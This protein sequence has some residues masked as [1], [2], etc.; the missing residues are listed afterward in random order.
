[1][2]TTGQQIL[3]QDKRVYTLLQGWALKISEPMMAGS[4][5]SSSHMMLCSRKR[6]PTC[7]SWTMVERRKECVLMLTE[8]YHPNNIY[9]ADETGLPF[10]LAHMQ[11]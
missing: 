1:M 8:D 7:D 3:W 6:V 9:F 2:V 4:A 5:I 11:T 10:R